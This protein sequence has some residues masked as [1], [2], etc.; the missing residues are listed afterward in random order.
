VNRVFIIGSLGSFVGLSVPRAQGPQQS[1]RTETTFGK[2]I[3]EAELADMYAYI[4]SIP[5]S[6]DPESIPLLNQID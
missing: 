5:A 1:R 2:Q 3:S 6:P 4:R